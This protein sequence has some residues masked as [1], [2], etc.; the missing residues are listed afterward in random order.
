MTTLEV[1]LVRAECLQVFDGSILGLRQ[2]DAE[3]V[4]FEGHDRD[5]LQVI[6]TCRIFEIWR[7]Q[8]QKT[9]VLLLTPPQTYLV[10]GEW[11]LTELYGAR[12]LAE[13]STTYGSA[14]AA[15]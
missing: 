13:A 4:I 1:V 10:P 7:S 15:G 9:L 2:H 6:S 12:L 14:V 11:N 5:F 3:Q 8:E